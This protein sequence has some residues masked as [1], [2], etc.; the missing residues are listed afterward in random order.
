MEK[1]NPTVAITNRSGLRRH[2]IPEKRKT[3]VDRR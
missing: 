3:V 2:R 1:R